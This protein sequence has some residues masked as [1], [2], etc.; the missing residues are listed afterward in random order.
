MSILLYFYFTIFTFF[1]IFIIFVIFVMIVFVIITRIIFK[2][3]LACCYLP[4]VRFFYQDHVM[5]KFTNFVTPGTIYHGVVG[6]SGKCFVAE[7]EAGTQATVKLKVFRET[8]VPGICADD[9]DTK[10]VS[11]SC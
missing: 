1:V 11:F 4:L 3:W 9:F 10:Q 5:F 6:N 8:K 7:E 2:K